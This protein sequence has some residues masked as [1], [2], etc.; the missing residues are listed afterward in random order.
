ML[1][2]I[3]KKGR[4]NY[5]LINNKLYKINKNKI[6]GDFYCDYIDDNNPII[7]KVIKETTNIITDNIVDTT[8]NNLKPVKVIKKR[9]IKLQP[10]ENNN[11]NDTTL[12]IKSKLINE[13]KEYTYRY[14]KPS[15]I[16]KNMAMLK[17]LMDRYPKRLLKKHSH[18][19]TFLQ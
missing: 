16:K 17:Y 19:L 6:Q 9:V 1:W 15:V 3:I 7:K 10:D 14:N 8:I 11:S 18:N 13:Q 12:L 4:T 2:K 5:Y